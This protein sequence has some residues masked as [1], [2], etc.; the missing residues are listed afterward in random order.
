MLKKIVLITGLR[1]PLVS[2]CIESKSSAM[3]GI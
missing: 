2:N 1:I 3:R